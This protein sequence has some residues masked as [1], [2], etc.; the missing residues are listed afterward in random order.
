MLS[1]IACFSESDT[2]GAA[3]HPGEELFTREIKERT[4]EATLPLGERPKRT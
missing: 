4:P 1:S 3:N 2:R